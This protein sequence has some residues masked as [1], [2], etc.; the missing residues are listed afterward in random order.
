MYE[1]EVN[2]ILKAKEAMGQ[3]PRRDAS[4]DKACRWCAAK[5]V[6]P[7]RR[8]R[9]VNLF[10]SVTSGERTS[11]EHL[12]EM[13]AESDAI[14]GYLKSVEDHLFQRV[15]DGEEIPGVDIKR[16]RSTRRWGDMA[17]FALEEAIGD[18]AFKRSLI[19]ITEAR[20]IKE[21]HPVIEEYT[22]KADGSMRLVLSDTSH[23]KKAKE[24][25]EIVD[26]MT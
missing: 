12:V 19:T 11:D 5:P 26:P 10:D 14:R 16:A 22:Y 7:A 18:R 24:L 21:A 2:V 3:N 9:H 6:C 15:R 8:D 20:K 23:A 25:F 17:D 13:F 4:S 1:F